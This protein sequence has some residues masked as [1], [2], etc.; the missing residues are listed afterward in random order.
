MSAMRNTP[1]PITI[2]AGD[3][4]EKYSNSQR[5]TTVEPDFSSQLMCFTPYRFT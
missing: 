5:N 2:P 1:V 3:R 4:E